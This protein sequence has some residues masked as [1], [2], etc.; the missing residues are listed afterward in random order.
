MQILSEAE[1]GDVLYEEHTENVK[2]A[3]RHTI[4]LLANESMPR[5][6]ESS[7]RVF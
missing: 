1:E 4:R 3:I 6:L 7:L 5:M 2:F